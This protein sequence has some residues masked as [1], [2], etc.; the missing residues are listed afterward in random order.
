MYTDNN[1][2]CEFSAIPDTD[3]PTSNA[4]TV[5]GALLGGVAGSLS[6]L[7][8]TSLLLLLLALVWTIKKYKVKKVDE[9]EAQCNLDHRRPN[10]HEQRETEQQQQ[11]QGDEAIEMKSSD[12]YMLTAQQIQTEDNVAYDLA[13]PQIPTEDN[14]AYG[15]TT[16]QIPTED[17][18]AYDQATP[19]LHKE[20]NVAYGQAAPQIPTEDNVAY[21]QAAPQIPTEDNYYCQIESR[22][23]NECEY[24]HIS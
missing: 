5:S 17:N 7:L 2:Y 20:D 9:N 21:G 15:Q 14:V 4:A 18:V 11:F 10:K 22:Y 1:N 19:Q 12:A 6:L 8:L 23:Q 24:E 13:T 16:P 3:S